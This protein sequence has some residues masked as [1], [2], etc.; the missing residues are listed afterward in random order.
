[1]AKIKDHKIGKVDIEEY[2]KGYSDFS[3]E[4]SALKKLISMGFDCQHSGTYEDPITNKTRQFDIRATKIYTLQESPDKNN[5]GII[6]FR[7][8][9]AVECKNI[10]DN[11]PLVIHCT[12]RTENETY[13]CLVRSDYRFSNKTAQC[14]KFTGNETFY[15]QGKY[16]GKSFDQVGRSNTG[17]LITSNQDVFDK[18]TQA[19]NSSYD[20]LKESHNLASVLKKVAI[21]FVLPVLVVPK[22]SIWVVNY[23]KSGVSSTPTNVEKISCYIGKQWTVT[24][25]SSGRTM[26][27]DLSHIE[28]VQIDSLAELIDDH[29]QQVMFSLVQLHGYQ[30]KP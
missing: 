8:C 23:N 17:E 24:D 9:L 1:M 19:N 22:D 11:F 26:S 18:I 15:E 28:I 25:N 14:I 29:F 30:L 5:D 3:F 2:L 4:I 10:R 21:S 6:I 16:V 7:L 20:L 27:Y 13:Q 12:P